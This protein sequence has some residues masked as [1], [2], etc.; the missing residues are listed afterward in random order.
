MNLKRTLH[1]AALLAFLAATTLHA[2]PAPQGT[3]FTYQGQLNAGGTYP[4]GLFQF[5]FTLYDSPVGGTPVPNAP[6]IQQSIQVINGL[7][8]TDLD[9][10]PAAFGGIQYWLDIQVG[11]TLNNEAPLASRQP[12]NAA[13]YALAAPVVFSANVQ[14][15]MLG[16]AFFYPPNGSGDTTVGGTWMNF[17]QVAV[18]MANACT[19]DRLY[20]YLSA[21]PAGRGG[22]GS[23]TVTLYV[24]GN[25]TPLAATADNTNGPASANVVGAV[26]VSVGDMVALQA[27]GV[28]I[29]QN[30]QGMISTSLRCR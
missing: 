24:N 14:N 21:V 6:Q 4:T 28:G 8:T 16:S 19:F 13:P 20:L 23:A 1:L 18:P 29:V 10:G 17:D 5:T 15:P 25:A 7:F 2:Q 26:A 3:S 9:F 27:S 30:G 11:T 22:G 12:I